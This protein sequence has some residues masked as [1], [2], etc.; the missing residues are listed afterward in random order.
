MDSNTSVQLARNVATDTVTDRGSICRVNART[1]EVAMTI[2]T[3]TQCGEETPRES[4]LT[5]VQPHHA[6][7]FAAGA[8]TVCLQVEKPLDRNWRGARMQSS[9]RNDA[10]DTDERH[11]FGKSVSAAKSSSSCKPERR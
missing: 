6:P 5:A 9:L 2:D 8:R 4:P 11:A 10:A 1:R 7:S 3:D